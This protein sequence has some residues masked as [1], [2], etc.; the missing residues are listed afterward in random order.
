MAD[1]LV[2][3]DRLI[4]AGIDYLHA[5]LGSALEARPVGRPDGPAIVTILR[6]HL[7]GRVPLIAAGQIRTPT[8]HAKRWSLACQPS[9]SGRRW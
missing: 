6:D 4:D 1:S 3:I 7:A 5:S 2:L 8:R 9:R